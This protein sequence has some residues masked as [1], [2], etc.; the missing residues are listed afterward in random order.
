MIRRPMPDS[1]GL[2]VTILACGL[3]AILAAAWLMARMTLRPPRMTDG[4]AA[5]L[6]QRVTPADLGLPF[7]AMTFT[8]PDGARGGDARLT[9]AA[10]WL[11]AP[12]A[13]EQTAV[14]L[15]GYADAKVGAL[16]WA[17]LLLQLN[18]NVLAVDL[19][20]H[21]ESG[22]TRTTAGIFERH[23]LDA[24]LN[25]LKAIKPEATRTLV[26]YGVSLGAAV[27]LATAVLRD[28][29]R[30]V[31]L[32]GPFTDFP[33]AVRI[34]TRLLGGPGGP[35]PWLASKLAA[36]STGGVPFSTVAPLQLLP[37][38]PCP[39]LVIHGDLDPFAPAMAREQFFRALATAPTGSRLVVLPGVGHLRGLPD[40]TEVYVEA[41]TAFL[42]RPPS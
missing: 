7:E 29:I 38:S 41:V 14:L 15:H 36:W 19:R 33:T 26:L 10:W 25:D 3:L 16:A 34:H 24:A 17:P 2:L 5:Y 4:K 18:F 12:V 20:A 37:R 23:D 6:L 35:V 42:S 22:G 31:V 1:L 9:L 21:G 8:V 39:V 30:A 11:P 28:D 27:A 32:D 13:S 40:A